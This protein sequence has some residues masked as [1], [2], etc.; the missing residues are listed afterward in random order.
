MKKDRRFLVKD[1][2]CEVIVEKK[3]LNGWMNTWK[4]F[5]MNGSMG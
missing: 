3:S 2:D 5:L 4:T 1:I